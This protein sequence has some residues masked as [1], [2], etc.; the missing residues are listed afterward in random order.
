MESPLT[1]SIGTAKICQFFNDLFD[2]VNASQEDKVHELKQLVIKE[3]IHHKFRDETLVFF[4]IIQF[5]EKD[6]KNPLAEIP[7]LKN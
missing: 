4:R 3:S 6:T 2:S 5:V 1:E 7:T